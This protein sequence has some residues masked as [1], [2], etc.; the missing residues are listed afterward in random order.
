MKVA[1][2]SNIPVF[3]TVEGNRS[4]VL[5]L[6]RAIK[7]IGHTTHFIYLPSRTNAGT[8]IDVSAHVSEFGVKQFSP[9]YRGGIKKLRYN[10]KRATLTAGR[11]IKA[12][13]GATGAYYF[14]LDELYYDGF[15]DQLRALQKSHSFDAV[16]VEYVFQSRA[17]SAF[18]DQI[19]KVLDTHDSFADRHIGFVG[20]DKKPDYWISLTPEDECKGFRRADVVVAI[21]E[22]EAKEFEARLGNDAPPVRVVS[23]F[24]DLSRRVESYRPGGATFVG[25]ASSPNVNSITY[26]IDRVL[27]LV[28]KA[29]PDFLLYVAGTV[30]KHIPD[31]PNVVKLGRVPHMV[32]A[33]SHAP[34]SVNPM[35]LGTGINIK[36]LEAMATAVHTVCTETGSRG[37]GT[38]FGDGVTIVPDNDAR[39]FADA[40]IRFAMS[41]DERE[42]AGREAFQAAQRWNQAQVDALRTIL[43]T[44][45]S[46]PE[47]GETVPSPALAS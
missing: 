8:D 41:P 18:P 24:L 23:H 3:P 40:V 21:Q 7:A 19:I 32:D 45:Q 25:S 13:L 22:P 35:L 39:A 20:S 11:K 46:V 37:L 12:K 36:L 16:F 17:F 6:A 34:L 33:F 28:V 43:R 14:E 15:T 30:C 47:N 44:S 4:R 27:P 1:I 29:V 38:G 42:R 9:L 2:V 10:V 31:Y 5:N 26:F